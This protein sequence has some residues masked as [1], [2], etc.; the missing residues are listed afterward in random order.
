MFT[1]STV[2]L[3]LGSRTAS[4]P[5]RAKLSDSPRMRAASCG[6]WKPVEFSASTKSRELSAAL[7]IARGQEIGVG[8]AGFALRSAIRPMSA[9]MAIWR[10][11]SGDPGSA[12]CGP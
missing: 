1:T 7:Q 10:R 8:L 4:C 5:W 12:R 3:K 2:G 6:G 11:A 9:V